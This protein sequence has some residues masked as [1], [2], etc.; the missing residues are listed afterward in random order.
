MIQVIYRTEINGTILISLTFP[1][2]PLPRESGRSLASEA[3]APLC[4]D[5]RTTEVQEEQ[6]LC[7]HGAA[8]RVYEESRDIS[9][10][11]A[12]TAALCQALATMEACMQPLAECFAE[13][14]LS[15][16]KTSVLGDMRLYL[17][18]ATRGEVEASVAALERCGQKEEEVAEEIASAGERSVE[19]T[20]QP[21]VVAQPEPEAAPQ[22]AAAEQQLPSL[23]QETRVV[24]REKVEMV[25]AA[26]RAGEVEGEHR[27]VRLV[28]ARSSTSGAATMTTLAGLLLPIMARLAV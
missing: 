7:T 19:A 14:D 11:A 10:T 15:Q 4:T 28:Q 12:L 8:T 6:Q 21:A 20:A 16:M 27:V 2:S 25:M 9:S 24:G 17:S 23:E 18:Q 5:A 3:A 26:P 13:E 22:N 1:M